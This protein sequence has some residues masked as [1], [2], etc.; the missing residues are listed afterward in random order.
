MRKAIKTVYL[1]NAANTPLRKEVVKAMAPFLQPL[2][3]GNSLSQNLCGSYADQAVDHA[4][5]IVAKTMRVKPEEVYFTSGATE[6]NNWVIKGLVMN[7]LKKPKAQ[8]KTHIVC[9]AIEHAS[10]LNACKEAEELGFSVTYIKPRLC[11]FI[12]KAQVSDAIKE[13]KTLLVCVMRVNNE[14]GVSNDVDSLAMVAH[15]YGALMLSDFTQSLLYGGSDMWIGFEYAHVDYITFSAHKIYGP[16]GVGCLIRRS[17]APLYPYMSGGSQEGGLRG[18][19][20]NVAAIVGLGKAVEVLGGEWWGEHYSDLYFHLID[21]LAK[22]AP[23][24]KVNCVPKHKGIV[25]LSFY[26]ATVIED[27]ASALSARGICVSAGAACS[28]GDEGEKISHVLKAMDMP[29]DVARSTIR[30]S[31]SKYTKKQDID[32]LLSA[33][34]SICEEFPKE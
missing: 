17:D 18:G 24:V 8:R 30:V 7:E 2:V 33:I 5:R 28:A 15:R 19:T 12:T 1:D 22:K 13:G 3:C 10:V 4:R 25:S 16:T 23:K 14:T 21:G 34:Q 29:D 32:A 26:K 9:S 20:H 11:G 31:M 6:S 27:V